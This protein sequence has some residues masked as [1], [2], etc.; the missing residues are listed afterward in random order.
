MAYSDFSTAKE[1]IESGKWIHILTKKKGTGCVHY[2]AQK[3]IDGTYC[4]NFMYGASLIGI[5]FFFLLKTV[6]K[7]LSMIFNLINKGLGDEI[8]KD[9]IEETDDL[10]KGREHKL[11]TGHAFNLFKYPK[12]LDEC[13]RYAEE[14]FN[15]RIKKTK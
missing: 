1:N 2:Y 14:E 3:R 9:I 4:V 12:T 15:N 6:C 11:S 5:P 7:L 8:F 10:L 13:K